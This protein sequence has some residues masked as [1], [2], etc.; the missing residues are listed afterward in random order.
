MTLLLRFVVVFQSLSRVW[1][2]D[3]TDW[4]MSG[5][6]VIHHLPEFT[7]IYVHWAN[8]AIL[9]SYPL[10]PTSPPALSLSQHQGLSIHWRWEWQTT[11]AF[12]PWEPHEQYEKAP[13]I[14]PHLISFCPIIEIT[15]ISVINI[16]NSFTQIKK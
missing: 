15:A 12:L 4:S 6:P 1:L 14:G 16:L 9:P 13:H 7:Q 8:D 2:C 10:S 11:S 5:F 3:S